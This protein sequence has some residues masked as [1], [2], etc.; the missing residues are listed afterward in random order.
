MNGKQTAGP[1]RRSPFCEWIR[2]LYE[3]VIQGDYGYEDGE[4]TVYPNHWRPM[5]REGLTPQQAFQRALDAHA[6]A[7]REGDE[8]RAANW[9]RIQAE[10]AIAIAKAKEPSA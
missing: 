3:D 8:A 5:W 6:N 9:M 10:D 2:T 1:R 7:R 4:F